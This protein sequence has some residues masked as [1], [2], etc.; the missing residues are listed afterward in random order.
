MRKK[1]VAFTEIE[2]K[3]WEGWRPLMRFT[4]GEAVAEYLALREKVGK[5]TARGCNLT[6]LF[7]QANLY[8]TLRSV[9]ELRRE[10]VKRFRP[11]KLEKKNFRDGCKLLNPAEQ[12]FAPNWF[13]HVVIHAGSQAPVSVARHGMRG[14]RDD[15]DVA[16]L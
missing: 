2:E 3:I 4:L 9:E 11:T 5:L 13:R 15:R 14:N 10:R 1:R 8:A 7:E 6:Y 16:A 12:F